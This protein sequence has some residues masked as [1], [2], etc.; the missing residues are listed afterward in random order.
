MQSQKSSY[1]QL[2]KDPRWQKKRLEILNRDEFKCQKCNDGKSSLHVHH[3]HYI[4]GKNPWEYDGDLL[5]TLCDSCHEYESA[6]L[7]E[8]KNTLLSSLAGNNLWADDLLDLAYVFHAGCLDEREIALI[9]FLVKNGE[10]YDIVSKMR[11]DYIVKIKRE[12]GNGKD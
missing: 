11:Q 7:K 1:F 5:I 2:L 4:Y 12:K 8:A 3:K 6:Y 10:A 9:T